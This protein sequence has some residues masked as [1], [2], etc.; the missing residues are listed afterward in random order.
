W[1]SE[2][3][4]DITVYDCVYFNDLQATE[5]SVI[6]SFSSN[7]GDFNETMWQSVGYQNRADSYRINVTS[8]SGQVTE[9]RNDF[10]EQ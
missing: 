5:T 4:E 9:L 1:T 6:S 2:Q 7:F 3:A 8:L 10:A